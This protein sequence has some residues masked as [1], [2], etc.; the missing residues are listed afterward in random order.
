MTK[1]KSKIGKVVISVNI[2]DTGSKL[3][4]KAEKLTSKNRSKI[5]REA[6]FIGLKQIAGKRLQIPA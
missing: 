2:G 6:L 1:A 3:L 4:D 5:V